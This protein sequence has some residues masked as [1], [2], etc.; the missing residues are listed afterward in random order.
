MEVK[1]HV[2][3]VGGTT[4]SKDTTRMVNVIAEKFGF[5]K[6]KIVMLETDFEGY[7]MFSVCGIIYRACMRQGEWWLELKYRV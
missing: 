5:V 1:K 7:A 4:V 3:T 2:K 6:S